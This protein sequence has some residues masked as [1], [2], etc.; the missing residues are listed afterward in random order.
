MAVV[1]ESELRHV[2]ITKTTTN[3]TKWTNYAISDKIGNLQ[4]PDLKEEYNIREVC[5]LAARPRISAA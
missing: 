4:R 2:H 3:K 5:Q 1:E